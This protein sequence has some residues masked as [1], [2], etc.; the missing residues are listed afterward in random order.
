MQRQ[1]T[2]SADRLARRVG[3]EMEVMVDSIDPEQVVARSWAD[4]PE[5][6]GK[7]YLKGVQT[8]SVVPGQ[9]LKV[10]VRQSDD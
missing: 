4:A 2:I 8:G 6:D 3:R 5:I 9:I 10:Q 7:G 1:A